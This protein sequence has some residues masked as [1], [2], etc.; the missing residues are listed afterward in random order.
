MVLG[1]LRHEQTVEGSMWI[2]IRWLLPPRLILEVVVPWRRL[3]ESKYG[4]EERRSTY[5][6]VEIWL[7]RIRTRRRWRRS[8]GLLR[9]E[10]RTGRS[11]ADS[12]RSAWAGWRRHNDRLEPYRT[13]LGSSPATVLLVT[14]SSPWHQAM[15]PRAKE[16][17]G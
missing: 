2:Y 5:D 9:R 12:A 6:L 11:I 17:K 15:S 8:L 4:R 10:L 14:V 16:P 1:A 3:T 7:R 13:S